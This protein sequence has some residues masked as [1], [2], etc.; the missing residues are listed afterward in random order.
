MEEE[1]GVLNHSKSI[2]NQIKSWSFD[3]ST[4]NAYR[5]CS[6]CLPH[7]ILVHNSQVNSEEHGAKV[8]TVRAVNSSYLSWAGQYK[9]CVQYHFKFT[10]V[11]STLVSRSILHVSLFKT[12]CQSNAINYPNIFSLQLYMWIHEIGYCIRSNIINFSIS[13]FKEFSVFVVVKC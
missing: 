4:K 7:A 1:L 12:D 9:K 8:E 10:S 3:E 5:S 6:S 2:E 13:K 11:C